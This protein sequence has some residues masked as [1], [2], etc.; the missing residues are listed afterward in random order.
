MLVSSRNSFK[1]FLLPS[2]QLV[3]PDSFRHGQEMKRREAVAS[4][5][6]KIVYLSTS[7]MPADLLTKG[8]SSAKHNNFVKKLGYL[9]NMP[10]PKE[11][12]NYDDWAFATSNYLL[13]EGI[14]LE[15]IP[16]A[17]VINETET[18]KAKAKLVMTID[19]SLYAHI[20]SETTMIGT[21]QKLKGTG[22]EIADE[23]IGSLLLAGLPDKFT[24]MI[25]AIEYSGIKTKNLTS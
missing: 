6:V 21:A 18:K 24:P 25:M 17:A 2:P 3:H 10:N 23:G 11:H 7:E 22:F 19:L 1:Y 20:K 16:D 12:E 9:V 4:R 13:L 5:L 15:N 14:D 8:L